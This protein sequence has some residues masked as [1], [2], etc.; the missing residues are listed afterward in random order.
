MKLQG[1]VKG[2][3]ALVLIDSGASHNFISTELVSQLGLHIE[4]TLTYT[5]RL[6]DGHKKSTSGCCPKVEL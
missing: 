2:R 1:I 3:T 5:V 4:S 6:G